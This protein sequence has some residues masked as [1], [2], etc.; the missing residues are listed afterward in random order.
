MGSVRAKVA[1]W[2]RGELEKN[3]RRLPNAGILD[4]FVGQEFSALKEDYK[5]WCGAAAADRVRELLQAG[6][7]PEIKGA[8]DSAMKEVS[9]MY[10]TTM[11]TMLSGEE[12][13]SIPVGELSDVKELKLHLHRL[14]G[15]PTRFRQRLLRGGNPMDDSVM[16]DSPMDLDLVLL[17][18]SAASQ[19][20]ACQ[21][22]EYAVR[23][24][25]TE[26]EALLQLPLDP[27]VAHDVGIHPLIAAS[28]RGHVEVLRLL[29]DAGAD[30]NWAS[31]FG[32]TALMRACH[33]GHVEV[34]R[35]LLDAG[36]DVNLATNRGETALYCASFR[37]HVE[38]VRLLLDACADKTL[39]VH[40]GDT[41]LIAASSHGDVEVVRLLLDAGADA[42][43]AN[44]DGATALT[45]LRSYAR[46]VRCLIRTCFRATLKWCVCHVE[47]VRLMLDA[48]AGKNLADSH[49]RLVEDVRA[50]AKTDR[51]VTACERSVRAAVQREVQRFE[52]ELQRP[53]ARRSN[54]PAAGNRG[55]QEGFLR[56]LRGRSR[57]VQG[58]WSL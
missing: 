41:A 6:G 43:L 45:S 56:R 12:V 7:L 19:R 22:V 4:F 8:M 14:H 17:T 21:L 18:Y 50:N 34:V 11:T 3:Q 52:A 27:D 46:A 5:D 38:V 1:L 15:L 28:L 35:L 37:G 16:L 44:I 48:C 36:A 42:N 40:D 20:Q 2:D 30:V 54:A 49:E 55:L 23:G 32:G 57:F 25:A 53:G 31:N 10:L 9:A 24:S 51:L 29:L 13:E 58:F 33:R 47:T 39:A 26:V